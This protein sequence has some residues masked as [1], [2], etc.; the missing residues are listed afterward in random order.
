MNHKTIDQQ[1][2][3]IKNQ[4]N[5]FLEKQT[6]NLIIKVILGLACL[7]ILSFF[8][9]NSPQINLGIA[10]L[11]GFIIGLFLGIALAFIAWIKN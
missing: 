1:I 9:P 8:L 7:L 3:E 5:K 10:L 4:D 2:Q 6:R 11:S